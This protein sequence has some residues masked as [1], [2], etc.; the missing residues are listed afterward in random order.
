MEKRT[1]GKVKM[2]KNKKYQCRGVLGIDLDGT[3]CPELGFPNINPPWQESI[4]ALNYAR[5]KGFYLILT[6]TRTSIDLSKTKEMVKKQYKMIKNYVK[7]YK[8]AIDEIDDGSKGKIYYDM[9]IDN[10][11]W[12]VVQWPLNKIHIDIIID[13]INQGHITTV[14]YDKDGK[15]QYSPK[16]LKGEDIK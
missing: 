8:L 13:L 10:K 15:E 12:L 16:I 6:S 3:I 11:G 4:E 9:M 1:K 5:K 14:T 2:K 7:K